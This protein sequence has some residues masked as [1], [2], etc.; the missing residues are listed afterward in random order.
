[1]SVG[2]KSVYVNSTAERMF[3]EMVEMKIQCENKC[4]QLRQKMGKVSTENEARKKAAMELEREKPL[5]KAGSAERYRFFGNHG[6]LMGLELGS[7]AAAI[8]RGNEAAH[9]W[10]PLADYHLIKEGNNTNMVIFTHLYGISYDS[11]E[12]HLSTYPIPEIM[13]ISN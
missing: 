9:H 4:E 13:A 6:K 2:S 3:N 7:S 12:S 10:N 5:K 1:M 8:R 11:V